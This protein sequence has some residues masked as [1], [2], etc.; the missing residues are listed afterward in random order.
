M[1][2]TSTMKQMKLQLRGQYLGPRNA[3][4]DGQ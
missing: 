3:Q 4:D 1:K 2:L